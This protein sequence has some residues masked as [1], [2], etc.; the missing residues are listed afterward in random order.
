MKCC[1][2]TEL[3]LKKD[4]HLRG[5]KIIVLLGNPNVGKT[6]VFNELTNSNQHV[7]NFP[8]VT[9]SRKHGFLQEGD[10]IIE[11]I[12]LPGTYSFSSDNLA[13]IV[14]RDWIIENPPD[15]I[16]NVVDASNLERNLYLTT[17]VKKLNIPMVIA[18]NMIDVAKSK[19]I[20]IHY[21]Q[22][23][24]ELNIPVVPLV[25]TKRKSILHFK[26]F[27]LQTISN[28]LTN[29]NNITEVELPEPDAVTS[30]KYIRSITKKVISRNEKVKTFSKHLDEV[31]THK[32]LSI[33]IFLGI[34]W[35]MFLFTFEIAQPFVEYMELVLIIISDL[36]SQTFG[37][38]QSLDLLTSLLTEGI[39]AGVGTVIIFVPNIFLLFLILAL[40]EDSG[41]L[42]RGAFIMDR[43]MV[44][45]GMEG[46]SLVPMITGFGC[47]VPAIM[48]TRNI[49][50]KRERV[51]TILISPFM[52]CSA[53][54][55]VFVLF[56]SIFFS[57]YASGVVAALYIGGVIV[58]LFIALLFK[59]LVMRKEKHYSTP[60][61]LEL[62]PYF[63]PRFKN[64]VKKSFK[65]STHFI[66]KVTGI[67]LIGTIIIWLLAHITLDPLGLQANI[68]DYGNTAIG[69]IGKTIEPIF[70]PLGFNW[71]LIV[72]LIF[73]LLAKEIIIATLG[74][75]YI[76]STITSDTALT[77]MILLNSGITPL[78]ALTFMV[79]VLLYVPCIPT[80][81]I[82]KSETNKKFAMFT[83]L[84]T[85][86][87]AYISAFLVFTIGSLLL[88]SG[89]L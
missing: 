43:L 85:S 83:V 28:N 54:L 33:P 61:F 37:K 70:K 55:P 79:F 11:I 30:Y 47:N 6:Q 69:L 59:K 84:Y 60:L 72:A 74:I 75:V 12:D 36:I 86:L 68:V 40:L 8:G 89:I 63:R 34:I 3:R 81:S 20:K 27:I 14:T 18:L 16:I 64:A 48:A 49:E 77:S 80:I 42:A 73:G 45:F 39:I 24:E 21:Q 46:R 78:V 1:N 76:G 26:E 66:K 10:L 19:G 9:V 82:I 58:A 62:P 4:N 52:S 25:A 32:Y 57:F 50:G 17:V 35:L 65:R 88:N 38:Y 22:L 31:F 7:G 15:L 41:Y 29:N 51:L 67:V 87:V 23:S 13:E 56:G 5:K 53:R 44:K 2:E 71:Q